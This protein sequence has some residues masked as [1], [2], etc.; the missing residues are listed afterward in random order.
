[1]STRQPT[2]NVTRAD[3]ERIVRRDFRSD[4][5]ATVFRMLER[6]A[7]SE[8]QRVQLAVLKLAGG[9]IDA[10]HHHLEVALRDPRDV[11]CSAEYPAYSEK[12]LRNEPIPSDEAKRLSDAD[13]KQYEE[14][15]LR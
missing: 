10:V 2:P 15:L 4:E 8:R 13:W 14:W 1:V 3:V 11:L 5:V 12:W 7:L 6:Y 9:D